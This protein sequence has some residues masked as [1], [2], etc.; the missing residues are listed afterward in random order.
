MIAS[1]TCEVLANHLAGDTAIPGRC[2]PG[3]GGRYDDFRRAVQC[4]GL[5]NRVLSSLRRS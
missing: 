3:D 1:V 4:A 5:R 2:G